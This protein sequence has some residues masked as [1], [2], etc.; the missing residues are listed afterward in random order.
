MLKV[1]FEADFGC[2]RAPPSEPL[3]A[4]HSGVAVA[5]ATP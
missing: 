1:R 3:T 5:D 2:R 4:T